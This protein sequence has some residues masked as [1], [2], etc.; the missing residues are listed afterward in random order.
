MEVLGAIILSLI[1]FFALKNSLIIRTRIELN[2]RQFLVED[3]IIDF[4]DIEY[5]KIHRMKGAG[6]TIKLKNGKTHRLSSNENFSDSKEF[7]RFI[8]DLE[9]D[10]F[11]RL[12][13]RK[14]KTFGETK[15]GFF[16]ALISTLI[17]LYMFIYKLKNGGSFEITS[18]GLLIITM[19]TRWSGIDVNKTFA[20]SKQKI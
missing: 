15:F 2:D 10:V 19:L 12:E 20:N 7:V 1:S 13:I 4:D 11:S 16:F 3:K 8:N 18:F 14:K 9:D 5:Y 6:L 17:F